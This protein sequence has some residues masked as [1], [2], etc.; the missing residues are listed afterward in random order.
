MTTQMNEQLA[1]KIV[2]RQTKPPVD[3][4]ALARDFGVNVW[5]SDLGSGVSGR[6]LRD[7]Q[8]GGES[9]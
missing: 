9:G 4:T 5:E 1:A 8:N 6:L 3:V 7:P 2:E